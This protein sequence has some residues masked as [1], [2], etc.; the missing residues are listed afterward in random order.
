MRPA[1]AFMVFPGLGG[2]AAPKKPRVAIHMPLEPKRP[3]K[4]PQAMKIEMTTLEP[5]RV[6]Y[7]RHVGPYQEAYRAWPGL[8]E[9]LRRDGV[10]CE[11]SL[12]IGVPM[13]DPRNTPPEKLRYDAC[14][15]VAENYV[16][17]K[18]V[19]VRTIPGGDYVVARNCRLEALGR[20][21]QELFRS[22]L[23][24]S[25][26]KLRKAPSFLVTV[27]GPE[28]TAPGFGFRDIYVPLALAEPESGR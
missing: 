25:G 19:R 10:R 8:R 18:P 1:P 26:R 7:L 27:N 11:G 15:T 5:R 6:A 16:P 9:R 13:D 28:G 24:K 22:W 3:V 14:V 20:C 4:N 23:P 2:E 12:L 21:Y 17:T